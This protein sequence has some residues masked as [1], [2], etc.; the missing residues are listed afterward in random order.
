[1]Q[2]DKVPSIQCYQ[3][4]LLLNCMVEYKVIWYGLPTI[5]CVMRSLDIVPQRPQA[6]DGWLRK[7]LICVELRHG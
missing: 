5:P 7:V 4:A 3:H 6:L 1:M 2:G